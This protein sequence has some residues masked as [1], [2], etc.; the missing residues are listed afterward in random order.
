MAVVTRYFSTAA[1]GAGDGTTWADR[2]ALFSSGNWSSIITA[3]DWT[4]NA[5]V[6]RI[7]P[8]TYT[9]SQVLQASLT[10]VSDPWFVNPLVLVGCDSSGNELAPNDPSWTCDKGP[11]D[12][13]GFPVI[14][15]SANSAIFA[16]N[17][18]H[19][20]YLSLK[21]TGRTGGACVTNGAL[22]SW[23]KLENSASGASAAGHLSIPMQ[24]CEI[25]MSG[26]Q[27]DYASAP[28]ANSYHYNVRLFGNSSASGGRGLVIGANFLNINLSNFTVVKHPGSGIEITNTGTSII[29]RASGLVVANNGGAGVKF[30][31]ATA[32]LWQLIS[33]AMITGNGGWGIDGGPGASPLIEG[34]RLRDNTSGNIT[35]GG[36]HLPSLTRIYTTDSSDADEYV[37]AANGDFRIKLGSTIY[38]MGFGVSREPSAGGTPTLLCHGNRF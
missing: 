8:G 24:N 23:C 10:T 14:G 36:D 22:M 34:V 5:L 4:S 38:D 17:N 12:V 25:V 31:N 21:A 37:D 28:G 19:L 6:A 35:N 29:L 13:T 30:A 20:R 33:R 3:F 15:W 7:G 9:V 16:L 1:A 2:A 27:Y 32:S 18:V 11:L 26:T